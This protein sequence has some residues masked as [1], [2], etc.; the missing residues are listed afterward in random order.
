MSININKMT[1][2]ELKY[3]CF[4]RCIDTINR[5]KDA[6][7]DDLNQW[8]NRI[9]KPIVLIPSTS[10]SL[11]SSTNLKNNKKNEFI[12]FNIQNYR[13][14]MMGLHVL[15]TWQ[16]SDDTKIYRSLITSTLK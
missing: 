3:A 7:R 15:K 6:M 14:A 16:R 13:L 4:E 11:L 1:N 10:S 2:E 8:I 12:E 9:Q 5:N